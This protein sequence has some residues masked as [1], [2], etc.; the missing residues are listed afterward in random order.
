MVPKVLTKAFDALYNY[1]SF[2]GPGFLIA[3]AYIDPGNYATDVSSPFFDL[4]PLKVRIP[5]ARSID[6][7]D[8]SPLS[9]FFYVSELQS[10]GQPRTLSSS[11]FRASLLLVENSSRLPINS[12]SWSP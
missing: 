4:L 10:S 5:L 1:A 2:V 12:A 3:V 6:D 9:S 8:F 11:G 7:G